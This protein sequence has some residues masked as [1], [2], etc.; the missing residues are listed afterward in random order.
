MLDE[1][2][3]YELQQLCTGGGLTQ[4][5]LSRLIDAGLSVQ[6]L[7]RSDAAAMAQAK[8][9]GLG[10]AERQ[11]LK[12]A[13]RQHR[14]EMLSS[15]EPRIVE[16]GDDAEA[17]HIVAAQLRL[18]EELQRRRAH[19]MEEAKGVEVVKNGAAR[20][21]YRWTQELPE[22]TVSVELPPGTSKGQVLC[23]IG[24]QSLVVG[25]RGLPPIVHGALHARVRPEECLWQLQD[26]HRLLITLP[27]LSVA[28]HECSTKKTLRIITMI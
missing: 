10:M 18:T 2:A 14:D 15:E 5:S 27:K 28:A 8:K 11:A 12:E 9:A 25:V 17:H 3:V 7:V 4:D 26:S 16:V 1:T 6:S 19:E 21:R 13:L 20:E 24:M 23:R 22:V